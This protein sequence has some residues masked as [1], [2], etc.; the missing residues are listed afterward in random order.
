M[1]I[2][3]D[4]FRF[5]VYAKT[6]R[7]IQPAQILRQMKEAFGDHAPSKTFVYKWHAEFSSNSNRTSF[8]DLERS[9]RPRSSLT[10]EN[11]AT[12]KDFI[13]QYPKSSLTVMSE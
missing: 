1:E 10:E 13:Q 8:L 7:R 4:Y 11:I 3:D 2:S 12:V 6:K 5:Y 9:G